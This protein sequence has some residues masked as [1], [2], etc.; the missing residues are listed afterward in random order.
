MLPWDGNPGDGDYIS[1]W[2]EIP[3]PDMEISPGDLNE[4]VPGDVDP[5]R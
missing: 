2:L 3:L 5:L 1:P 4:S